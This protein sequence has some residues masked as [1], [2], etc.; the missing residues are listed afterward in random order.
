MKKLLIIGVA[1]LSLLGLAGCDGYETGTIV[2]GTFKAVGDVGSYD[3]LRDVETGCTYL[4]SHT[5]STG[6]TP[7]FGEDGEVIGCG[8]KN[9]KPKY[10][11]E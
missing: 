5:S 3:I 1:S 7:Y 2:D 11:G 9:I 10:L 4:Q 6:I 8:Q